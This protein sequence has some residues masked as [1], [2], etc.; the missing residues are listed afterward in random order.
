MRKYGFVMTF[1]MLVTLT[2]MSTARAQSSV[3][4][5]VLG[6]RATEILTTEPI[7]LETPTGSLFGTLTLPKSRSPV[8]VVLIVA[9]SGP[10]D[11]DGNSP[12][13]KGANNSLK[14]VAEGL[15]A[16]GIASVRYDKRG[17]GETGKIMQLE[18][19]KTKS[20][21]R[22]Q[23]LSFEAF[24][25]DAVRWGKQLRADRRFSRLAVLGHSEGSLIGMVAAQRMGADTFISIAGA[26]RPVQQIILEQVRSQLPPELLKTTEDILDQLSAGKTVESVPAELQVLFRPSVQPYLIS[27]LRYDPAK[28]IAKLCIPVLIVQGTTDLQ[29]SPEDAKRLVKGNPAAKLLFIEGMNHV[30]KTVPNEQKSQVSSYGDPTLPVAPDL[31][32][33]IVSFAKEN[34]IR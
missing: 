2:D 27:W 28:E 4:P 5:G 21:L 19:E 30:L 1:V 14:L 18:A 15:A 33:V 10:T 20:V 29:A 12:L 8:P 22:E 31:I 23:D 3:Q 9:G 6:N 25:D 7:T 24:I 11:R 16:H 34:R 32:G 17:V 13:L 26:G